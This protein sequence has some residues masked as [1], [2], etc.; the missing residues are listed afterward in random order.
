MLVLA[1]AESQSG[2]QQVV[3]Q[4]TSPLPGGLHAVQGEGLR[5]RFSTVEMNQEM[6]AEALGLAI[7]LTN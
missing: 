6:L 4:V 5:L 3:A 1:G 2:L 7:S